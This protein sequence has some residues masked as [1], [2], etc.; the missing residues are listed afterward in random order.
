MTQTEF[1]SILGSEW[2]VG[3]GRVDWF[4]YAPGK[5]S[6]DPSKPS[7]PGRAYLHVVRKDDIMSLSDSVR[8]STWEDVKAT[9]NNPSLIG[10]PA[11][12]FAIYKKIPS[13]KKRT[14][15]RQG[16]ID[17]DPEFMAF[18][19]DL[20]NPAPPNQNID[21]DDA[22]DIAKAES[23][24]TTTPLIEYLKEKK[25]NKAKDS[26]GSKNSKG[27]SRGG[28]GKGGSKDE[29]SAKKRS[30]G[31]KAEKAEK[32][33]KAPKETVKI[34]TKKA[35][36]EQAATAAKNAAS[37][38]KDTSAQEVP[39]SRRAGIA[40]AARI[41]QRDLGLSPGSA[42]RKARQDAAK[43]DTDTKP[44]PNKEPA[45]PATIDPPASPAKP[46]DAPAPTPK[47]RAA[48]ASTPKSQSQASGRRTR[49]GKNPEKNSK[50]TEG[51]ASQS[52][53]AANPPVVLLKKKGVDAESSRPSTP[54]AAPQATSQASGSKAVSATPSGPKGGSTKSGSSQKK[55]ATVTPDATR[56]FVKHANPSQGVTEALLKQSLEIFGT[57]TFVEIDKRKGFAYVDFSE[58][59]GLVKAVSASPIT[60][61]QGTVQVL[62]RKDKKP[63][64]ATPAL[65]ASGT[66]T[67]PEKSSGRGRRG[68]GG[69]GKG[70]AVNSN[71]AASNG[72]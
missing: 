39:K 34:L 69:G 56:G 49:G 68:R 20:A 41:L 66:T 10:P 63:V 32:P 53:G 25:A 70:N 17:Q 35:A 40:A 47:N 22:D 71:Q 1:V 28:K 4:S 30:K 58:H 61:A 13:N 57:I 54:N 16:T 51:G 14:D 12:E 45:V 38:I 21:A 26:S 65:A 50:A 36:I 55:P 46:A 31:E 33:D 3:K 64:T 48:S 72:G 5:I 24:V 52:S 6:N 37:Q 44:T 29:E 23:K 42:H 19:E 60:V 9:F 8:T 7:R 62:E 59:E 18:L 27:E 15:A 43:A 67:A 2:D 11:V